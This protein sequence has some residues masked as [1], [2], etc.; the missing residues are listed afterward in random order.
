MFYVVPPNILRN[1]V[2]THINWAV[3][4]SPAIEIYETSAAQ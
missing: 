4:L 3:K 1:Y 2:S